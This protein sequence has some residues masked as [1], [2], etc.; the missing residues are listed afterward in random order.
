MPSASRQHGWRHVRVGQNKLGTATPRARAGRT[1]WLGSTR[2]EH[3]RSETCARRQDG[4]EENRPRV[5]KKKIASLGA[6][7]RE[8]GAGWVCWGTEYSVSRVWNSGVLYIYSPMADIINHWVVLLIN[9]RAD[10]TNDQGVVWY[11]EC[12]IRSSIHRR[13]HSMIRCQSSP[14][15]YGYI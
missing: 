5:N 4:T 14:P 8:P 3:N 13:L 2:R 7:R 11:G 9:N 10:T 15:A 12:I 6:T 1:G